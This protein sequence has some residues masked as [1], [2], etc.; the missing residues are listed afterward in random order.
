V[1]A[2][3]WPI[4]FTLFVW[5]FSTGAVLYAVGM[6]RR[7]LPALI[8]AASAAAMFGLFG[9]YATRDDTSV[10]AAFVA[11]TCGLIV[12]AWH[13]MTF[14][15][16]LITGPR[17]TALSGRD[18][19][20]GPKRAPLGPAIETVI[21]HEGAIALTLALAA[22]LTWESANLTGLWTLVILW[23]MRLS[24][25][26]NVYLGVPNLTEQF[27]PAHLAYL[28][29]Y[30]CRRPMNLLFPVSVTV[31]T[32]AAMLMV[33][34]AMNP[35]ATDFEIASFSL[36]ATLMT[37][38]MIEHWFLVVPLPSAELWSWGLASRKDSAT[39][40]DGRTPPGCHSEH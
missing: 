39:M 5:W 29:G 16:G 30:F 19:A 18:G 31:S 13:E 37:L 21:Y 15:T 8:T 22:I 25:K 32:I 9:L 35:S 26:F 20:I 38:A 40:H 7:H 4:L 12:W 28:K 1:A 24:A 2:A 33:L 36:L 14:L 10:T 34:A 6:P 11:F 17:T 23:V 27:L 3:G